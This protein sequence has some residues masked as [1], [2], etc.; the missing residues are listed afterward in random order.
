MKRGGRLQRHRAAEAAAAEPQGDSKSALA[1]YLVETWAWGSMPAS[2]VQTIAAKAKSD[3]LCHKHIESLASLGAEGRHPQNC[4]R[5]LFGVLQSSPLSEARATCKLPFKHGALGTVP[6]D[7][8][9]LLPHTLFSAIYHKFPAV[10]ESRVSGPPGALAAFWGEM[11]GNPVYEGHP[12]KRRLGHA[13]HAVPIA[14]HGDG[15]PVAGIGK[16]WS[17]SVDCWSW[18]SMIAQGS[19]LDFTFLIYFFFLLHR[20]IHF[21]H[22]GN[23]L[24]NSVLEPPLVISRDMAILGLSRKAFQTRVARRCQSRPATGQWLLRHVVAIER[25]SG[26][27]CQGFEVAT[28][29]KQ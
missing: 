4:Q 2:Q 20:D 10:F 17:K 1:D 24:E 9:I 27:L 16:S 22:F 19:T 13:E 14:I 6:N 3:G 11:Q 12:V 7:Q 5:D 28:L 21:Q 15:V 26:L 8:A 25:R 29:R 23:I 18:A